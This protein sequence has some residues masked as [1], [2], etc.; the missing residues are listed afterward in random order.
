MAG[1]AK[2]LFC[3]EAVLRED[4]EW[5]SLDWPDEEEDLAPAKG[6]RPRAVDV[7]K[8]LSSAPSVTRQTSVELRG[9]EYSSRAQNDERAESETH[10]I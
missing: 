5:Q 2:H 9:L 8:E 7:L 3:Y 4:L 1:Q 6:T 10:L